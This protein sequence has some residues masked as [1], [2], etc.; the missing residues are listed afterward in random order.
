MRKTAAICLLALLIPYITT[1]SW[2][3]RVEGSTTRISQSGKTILLDR[4]GASRS[5]EREEYL[6]GILAVQ[7]PADYEMEA[8]KAQAI[9]ARTALCRQMEGKE[10]IAES[11]LDMDYLEQGQMEAMWG[12]ER[13]LE[14]YKRLRSAVQETAG[15]VIRCQGEYID[16]LFH[17]LS[18]GG[19]RAGDGLHPYLASVKEP[20]DLQ[21]ENF[22][23]I[24]LFTREELAG[25]L[26]AMPDPP[27]VAPE[28][29]FERIHIIQ[30]DSAGYVESIQVGDKSYT[31]DEVRYALG[32]PSPA[33]R[34]E[35]AEGKIRCTTQGIGHGFGL[36]QYGA[37]RKAKEGWK[38]E[39]IL[40]FYYKNIVIVSE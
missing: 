27:G 37:D 14:N 21:G 5:I 16:P 22:M 33:Y 26:N 8:L 4:D 36:D 13:Y 3:G 40:G 29:V 11:A 2:T 38:A 18:A 34:F 12:R 28:E 24:F 19:T 15:Q 7:I 6:I 30:K 20:D 32:L 35:E 39:D 17:R 25:R 31:G 1:L 9:A 10:T 23:G